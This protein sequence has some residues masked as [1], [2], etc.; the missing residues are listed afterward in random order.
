MLTDPNPDGVCERG[1]FEA[2]NLYKKNR[3]EFERIA[4]EWTKKYAC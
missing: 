1:N 2:A 4:R 3:E